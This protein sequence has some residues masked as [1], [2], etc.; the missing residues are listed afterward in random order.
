MKRDIERTIKIYPLFY[1]L[2]ADTIFFVPID[3]LF[4]TH[5]KN[6][7]ANNIS[8][9]T[10]ISLLICIL[11]QKLIEKIVKKIGNL[12][13]LRLGCLFLLSSVLLLTFGNSFISMA[14][15]KI[16]IEYANMFW[17]MAN[18]LLKNNLV[19]LNREEDYFL[20]KNKAKVLYGI[21]TMVTALISGLLFNMNV[22]Y[23]LYISIIIYLIALILSMFFKEAK[24]TCKKEINNTKSIKSSKLVI[25]VI[26]SYALFYSFMK[27]GQCNSKLFMQYDFDKILSLKDVTYLLSI[28]VF[29]SRISRIVGTVI[30]GK[31][32]IKI[33]DKL[34]ILLTILEL[35]SFILLIIGHYIN[36]FPLKVMIMT[37]GFC[38]ILGIRD[39]FQIYIEDVVL[40]I[41]EKEF[42]QKLMIKIEM[43]R[44]I[45]QLLLS[46]LFTLI[47][48]KYNLVN[49]IVI[50]GIL[51]L[52]EIILNKRMYNTLM[53]NIL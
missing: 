20:I 5:V 39:S 4:L 40:K 7:S 49:I 46:L 26:L 11:S 42:H 47:L 45:M 31:I 2:T 8:A 34:S 25:L 30:L 6:L 48:A 9:L 28:I 36:F 21:S 52:L 3:V 22:Y 13:S 44:K 43:N 33:K 35:L 29:I 17:L 50:F 1:S 37:I 38:L 23:P 12:N 32:Y 51:S 53:D 15:Y 18:V 10:T 27:L 19:Y 14:L 41:S 24:C 16:S